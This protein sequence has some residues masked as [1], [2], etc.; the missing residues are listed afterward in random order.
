MR[1]T[2]PSRNAAVLHAQIIRDKIR[3]HGPLAER[4]GNRVAPGAAYGMMPAS[5]E[6]RDHMAVP[7]PT[8]ETGARQQ[9][10]HMNVVGPVF[11]QKTG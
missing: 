7:W 1:A 6:H 8:V 2:A 11:A 4:N 3:I 9:G 10:Q 5:S